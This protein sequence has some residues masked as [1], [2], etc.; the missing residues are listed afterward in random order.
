MQKQI[1]TNLIKVLEKR[2]IT[3]LSNIFSDDVIF[4]NMAEGNIIQG[5]QAVLQKFQDFF[6]QVS[7]IFWQI[8]HQLFEHDI[9]ITVLKNHISIQGKKIILPMV[10][11]SKYRGE[12]IYSFKDYFDSQT[13]INQLK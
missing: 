2:D 7:S 9:S 8:E 5:K 13:F 12:Q 11:V 10:N 4:E 1:F 3:A 6:S